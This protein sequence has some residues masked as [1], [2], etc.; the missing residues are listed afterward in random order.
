MA[1]FEL[2]PW[3]SPCEAEENPSQ[4]TC[5]LLSDSSDVLGIDVFSVSDDVRHRA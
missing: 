5:T 2:L 1:Y 3:H 4:G